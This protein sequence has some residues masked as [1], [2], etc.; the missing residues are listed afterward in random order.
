MDFSN[1]TVCVTGACGTVGSKVMKALIAQGV[2]RL[3]GLDNN[4][5]AVFD[6]ATNTKQKNV[7]IFF[8]DIRN[9]TELSHRT[10]GVDVVIHCAAMKHVILS[11]VSPNET[12][13]TN[14]I[15]VQNVI[16]AAH[17]NQIP[18]TLFTSSDKAVNPTNVMGTS[19][20]MGERLI[21][22]AAMNFAKDGL[23]F[24]STR[25]G[26]VLGSSGSV[27]PIFKHQARNN[28]ALTLTHN[29][30]T[31]FIMTT[32]EAADL[33]LESVDLISCGEVI[34]TKMQAI[35]IQDLGEII[36]DYYQSDKDIEIIGTKPGEKLYEELVSDEERSRSFETDKFITIIPSFIKH[37]YQD[38][39][40]E[41][42]KDTYNSQSIPKMSKRELKSYLFHRQLLT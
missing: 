28:Q 38:R 10:K 39:I 1:K 19:K 15:G 11:E 29:D 8:C 14:I 3:I 34:V 2:S 32:E 16:T 17:K 42:I 33:V 37:E 7:S 20:L 21:S 23:C 18:I 31:R 26:N 13:L 41:G 12:V 35:Y 5:S 36:I 4:E 22:S 9:E 40:K 30:M 6:M 24:G 27:L 25:F